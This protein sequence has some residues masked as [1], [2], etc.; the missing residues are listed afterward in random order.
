MRSTR[1]LPMYS[2]TPYGS[3][4]QT[5]HSIVLESYTSSTPTMKSNVS[6]H[7]GWSVSYLTLDL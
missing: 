1:T 7:T 2:R 6:S 3:L 5:S 4:S